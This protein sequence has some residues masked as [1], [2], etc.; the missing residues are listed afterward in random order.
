MK[1]GRSGRGDPPIRFSKAW[2]RRSCRSAGRTRSRARRCYRSWSRA[3]TRRSWRSRTGRRALRRAR[4]LH[5]R[6]EPGVTPAFPVLMG[7][8]VD[9]LGRPSASV[10]GSRDRW[11]CR[12]HVARDRARGRALPFDENGGP[13]H[14]DAWSSRA[15]TSSKRAGHE[16]GA[17]TLGDRVASNL[18][19]EP[20]PEAGRR[21]RRSGLGARGG[22]RGTGGVVLVVSSGGRGS[23]G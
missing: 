4:L 8:A 13:G 9:W 14:G 12:R 21:W 15:C 16:R 1:R 6:I 11:C 5:G 19:D 17:V 23:V 20:L 3:A 7:N 10:A 2:T 22:P 18:L